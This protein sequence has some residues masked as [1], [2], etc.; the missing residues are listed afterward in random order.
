MRRLG[1]SPAV[2]YNQVPP[3]PHWGARIMVSCMNDLFEYGSG[4]GSPWKQCFSEVHC[5]QGERF[6]D[7]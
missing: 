5:V 7:N 6:F 4:M 2:Y 1:N 3:A